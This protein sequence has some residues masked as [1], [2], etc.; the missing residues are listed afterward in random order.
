[1]RFF[2]KSFGCQMNT[3]D[4]QRVADALV[5]RGFEQTDVPED[6]NIM[7]FNTCSIRE[8][9][10]EKLFSDLGRAKMF[11]EDLL[12][13]NQP[14]VVAV[15]GCVSQIQSADI[16][17]RAPYVDV[18]LGTQN[19]YE[20][21]DAIHEIMQ[22]Q[23][24]KFVSTDF[25]PNLKFSNL[26]DQF[27]NRGLSEFITI[28]EGCNN[29]CT[30]CVVPFTSGREFSRDAADILKEARKLL[31]LGVKEIVL[32]GQ[33]VDSYHGKGTDGKDWSL[34]RLLYAMAELEGL[35]RL[36]YLTSNP[37][38]IDGDIAVAHREIEVLM[39]FLHIPAQ[40]GSDEILRRMNRRYTAEK[41]LKCLD[42]LKNQREDFAFSSD[43]I[44]GFPGE[45]DEDFQKTMD[46]VEKVRY[47]QAYSFKYS[48]RPGTVAAKMPDQIPEEVKSERLQALQ[49]VLAKHQS[50]FNEKFVGKHVSVLLTKEGRHE[51]QLVGR[52]EYA[53][54]V[55]IEGESVVNSGAKVGE[56]RKVQITQNAPHSL[57]GTIA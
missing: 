11:K 4:S 8:K 35:K 45:T 18:I 51:N 5:L 47:A 24:E 20:V 39:P 30:Y 23:V 49:E 10:D 34:A 25:T 3:Y 56:I 40:S 53:Q 21:V 12:A 52:S 38:D 29:F 16:E 33:N 7:I 19:I 46:L 6:A 9:A 2:I 36:R 13:K 57:I 37:Q 22:K 26:P 15:M 44:V 31:S 41:Y 28:Q 54:A 50:E 27:F 42:M 48:P 1:M 17:R 14:A 55:S 32:L 43:F